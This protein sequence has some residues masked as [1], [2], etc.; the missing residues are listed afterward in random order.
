MHPLFPNKDL[1][2]A[3]TQASKLQIG[4]DQT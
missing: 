2:A 3:C 1:S 4:M